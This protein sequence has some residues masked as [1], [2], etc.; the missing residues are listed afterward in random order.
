MI[1]KRLKTL[2]KVIGSEFK[3]AFEQLQEFD[4]KEIKENARAAGRELGEGGWLVGRF[5]PPRA[6]PSSGGRD[7]PFMEERYPVDRLV[8]RVGGFGSSRWQTTISGACAGLI[9]RC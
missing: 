5:M 1:G 4:L 3:S 8:G 7:G 9:Q 2:K 6:F